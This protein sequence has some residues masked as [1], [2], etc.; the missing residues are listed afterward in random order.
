MNLLR[1]R[2]ALAVVIAAAVGIAAGGLPKGAMGADAAGGVP[3]ELTQA[4]QTLSTAGNVSA[5]DEAVTKLKGTMVEQTRSVIAAQKEV[6][7]LQDTLAK[8]LTALT[9]VKDAEGSAR[10]AGL[11]EFNTAIY[12]WASNA[13]TLEASQRDAVL[14]WGL[15]GDNLPLI[16][17]IYGRDHD[18]KAEAIHQL[19]KQDPK[20]GD[21]LHAGGI[22]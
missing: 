8:E 22:A 5:A 4:V 6:L 11:L 10:V 18:A 9:G 12:T 17:K 15:K 14:D 16:A 3:P 7:Q 20:A 2:S 19:A 13:A 1:R 21:G